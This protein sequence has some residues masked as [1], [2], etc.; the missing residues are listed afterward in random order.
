MAGIPEHII[1]RIRESVNIVE[2]ISRYV[3]LRK[4]GRNFQG[5]CPFHQEKTPSFSVNP[6]KQIFHCFGCGVGGNVF[7]FL[8]QHE[9]LSFVDAVKRLAEET[10]IE[11]PVSAETRQRI[12]ENERLL[13]ANGVAGIFFQRSLKS[14]P[15]EVSAYL[16]KRGLQPETVARFMVGYAPEGWDG[17]LKHLEQK[18]AAV[19]TYLELGL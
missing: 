11:I 2:V 9:K 7:S 3:T 4:R 17:L 18:K 6:E 5:L 16:K 10:G 1:D 19:K 13:N 15:A 14:A 8:M 12:G